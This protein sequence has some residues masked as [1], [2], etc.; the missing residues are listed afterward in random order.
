M[1]FVVFKRNLGK[2][3]YH[4]WSLETAGEGFCITNHDSFDLS[5]FL[6]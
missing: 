2:A 1:E 4:K 6:T 5:T 3:Y